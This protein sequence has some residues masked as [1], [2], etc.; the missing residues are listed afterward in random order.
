M[1]V[2]GMSTMRTASIAIL[3]L[4]LGAMALGSAIPAG[5]AGPVPSANGQ[6]AYASYQD[7]DYDIYTMDPDGSNVQNLTTAFDPEFGAG[8]TDAG[9]AWS[10][11]GTKLTFTSNRDALN[12]RVWVMD[13]DGSNQAALTPD[14][15]IARFGASW[16]PDGARIAYTMGA[17]YQTTFDWDI[18]VMDADGTNDVDITSPN[19]TL[20]YDDYTPSW[21]PDGSRIVFTGVREG[22]L[23]ILS[24]NP[25]GTGEL[26]LTADDNPPYANINDYASY[27]PDGSKIVYMSQ[28]ND[29]SNEWDIW[30]MNPDGTGKQD[31]LADD[32]FEDVFPNWTPDGAHIT[33]TGNRSQFGDDVYLMDYPPAATAGLS[34]VA[35]TSVKRLTSDGHAG[36]ADIQ[37]LPVRTS[38][39]LKAIL[40]GSNEIPGPGDPDGIARARITVDA[41]AGTLCYALVT[42]RVT[43]PAT[44]AHVLRGSAGAAGAVVATLGAPGADGTSKGCVTGVPR[45]LLSRIA[46]T[47]TDFSVSI[48]TADYPQGAVRGQLLG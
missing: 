3:S 13:A 7:G 39:T 22:A 4:L 26:N 20:A 19:Q 31:V 33:F 27:R 34:A 47:P 24:V 32:A 45:A 25:D 38:A 16:S 29:G 14:D 48:E 28:P 37:P 1:E 43:L 44:G 12:E 30:V 9:P 46:T 36:S 42:G 41:A 8:W 23:E 6:L 17:D 18:H 40:L 11:D 21:S 10:P 35:A 15:G 5:A 2:K